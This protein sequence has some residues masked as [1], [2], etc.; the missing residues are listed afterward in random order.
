MGNPEKLG[1]WLRFCDDVSL[2]PPIHH[3][4]LCHLR[5]PQCPIDQATHLL[6]MTSWRTYCFR[7]DVAIR[8]RMASY[9]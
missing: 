4:R 8:P 7:G 2:L 5:A 9:T 6:R 3:P 1:I